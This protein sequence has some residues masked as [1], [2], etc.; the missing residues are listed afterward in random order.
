MSSRSNSPKPTASGG[1]V[2]SGGGN[3]GS[4]SN[5]QLYAPLSTYNIDGVSKKKSTKQQQQHSLSINTSTSLRESSLITFL[6]SM[7]QSLKTSH[8][9][10]EYQVYRGMGNS[11]S[12]F[13]MGDT[14]RVSASMRGLLES[15]L[16]NRSLIL[17]GGGVHKVGTTKADDNMGNNSFSLVSGMSSHAVGKRERKRVGGNG[18]FG[19]ISNK[20]RKKLLQQIS[21]E[22]QQKQQQQQQL[23]QSKEKTSCELQIHDGNDDITNQ[24]GIPLHKEESHPKSSIKL[25]I[26]K[27]VKSNTINTAQVHEKVGS[28][29]ETLHNMWLS[30]IKQ[31]LSTIKQ[32]ATLDSSKSKSSQLSVHDCKQIS[33][34]LATAEHVGMAATIVECPSRRHLVHCRCVIVNETKETY[35]IALI[36]SK[37]NK[38]NKKKKSV[39]KQGGASAGSDSQKKDSNDKSS[40]N[41]K[42]SHTWKIILL[43]KQ[44]T[45]L[46]I[47]LPR[48]DDTVSALNNDGNDKVSQQKMSNDI[49]VRLK[50]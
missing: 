17:V 22:K 31:L 6:T 3:G 33:F 39:E 10:H 12:K 25:E 16:L 4:L 35:S 20:K 32:T 40:V 26:V 19:S 13:G 1:A 9:S 11:I 37:P 15:K 8:P 49:T 24:K 28:V 27:K 5:D 29:V 23:L 46:D 30:Y 36:K 18:I 7:S 43:P 2:S 45:V 42:P 14:D 41:N 50:T 34:L 21:L 44:G 38:Q 47:D 48:I